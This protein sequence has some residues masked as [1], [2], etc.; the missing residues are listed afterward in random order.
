MAGRDARRDCACQRTAHN[1]ERGPLKIQP[2]YIRVLVVWVAVLAA[3]YL[4][5]E[6]FS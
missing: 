4:L 3:L 1:P 6:T 2:T 5:Q